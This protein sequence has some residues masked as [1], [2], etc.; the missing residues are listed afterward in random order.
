M[1]IEDVLFHGD[2]HVRTRNQLLPLTEEVHQAFNENRIH[3]YCLKKCQCIVKLFLQFLFQSDKLGESRLLNGLIPPKY[4]I[5]INI[6]FI[7]NFYLLSSFKKV[8]K[9]NQRERFCSG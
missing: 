6:S 1:V 7:F 5:R 4:A 2:I 3:S 9:A 8:P